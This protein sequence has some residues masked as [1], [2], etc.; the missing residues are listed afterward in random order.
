MGWADLF[1]TLGGVHCCA[2]GC[3][4]PGTQLFRQQTTPRTSC[5]SLMKPLH[6]S[7][8]QPQTGSQKTEVPALYVLLQTPLPFIEQGGIPPG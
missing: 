3:L 4:Y 8:P 1:F 2:P 6:H 7:L 5:F